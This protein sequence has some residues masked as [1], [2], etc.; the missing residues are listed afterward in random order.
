MTRPN[1]AA[2]PK[3]PRLKRTIIITEKID[4][5]N[6]QIVVTP[7]GEV[8][9]GS[10]TR[11]VTPEN[12]NFGF[13]TWVKHNETE[14]REKLGVGT[15]YGEWWGS[16]IQRGYGLTKKKFSLFNSTRWKD[17]GLLPP[18]VDVVP[19]LFIGELTDGNIEAALTHLRQN[20]SMAAPGFMNPEGVV[21]YMTASGTMHKVLLENDALPKGVAEK[22]SQAGGSE[23][24]T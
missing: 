15:H 4:G 8:F 24:Q 5:T 23:A 2:F 9:A 7:E 22:L 11:Y 10:R 20:G 19:T 6:A 21:I 18:D 1:F 12:D 16:G 17:V 14:I 13:A 3:I